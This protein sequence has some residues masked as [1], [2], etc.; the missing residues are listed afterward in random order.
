M[1]H[2]TLNEVAEFLR[3]H[4]DYTILTHRRPDG[5]TVG[6]ADALCRVL[7]ALGKQAVIWDNPDFRPSQR[8]R[9]AD[10]IEAGMRATVVAVDVAAE[11]MLPVNFSGAVALCIDHHGSNTGYAEAGFVDSSAAACG[12]ILYT[13]FLQ[14][15]AAVSRTT[16]E[17]LYLAISTDTGCFRYAN[18]TPRTLRTAA[19]L[20]ECGADTAAMNHRLFEVKTRARFALEA[21]LTETM[22]LYG[23][24]KIGICQL[25]EAEK[26]RMGVTEDD[27]DSIAGFARDLEGVEIAALLRDL[28]DAQCK[29]SLRTETQRWDASAICA[30]LGGGGHRGAAGATVPGSIADGRS[31]L[32]GAIA[33][34]TGLPIEEDA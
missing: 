20:M 19:A 4:D 5:D 17:A 3:G 26:I 14:M 1:K 6:C 28:P 30:R 33:A 12:E 21:Y 23:G 25:P 9:R 32:L 29:I 27:A 24:G 34:V 7:R 8:Q 11:S 2:L 15:G 18:T 10:L 22:R 16:A 31:A 13:L